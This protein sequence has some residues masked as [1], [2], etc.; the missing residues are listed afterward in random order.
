[1]SDSNTPQDANG[2]SVTS[3]DSVEDTSKKISD[4]FTAEGYQSLR[5]SY[6]SRPKWR[7]HGRFC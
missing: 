4:F 7:E 1:M 6:K 2:W 3:P 5:V